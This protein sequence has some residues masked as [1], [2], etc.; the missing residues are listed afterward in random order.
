[1]LALEPAMRRRSSIIIDM[2]LSTA[3]PT[4][5]PSPEPGAVDKSPV[6]L[7][8]TID[9]E[10]DLIA[11]KAGLGSLLKTA[12]QDVEVPEFDMNSFF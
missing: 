12:R 4:R 3:P 7:M 1:M 8:K 5:R 9:E 11:R 10:N 2:D 6:S